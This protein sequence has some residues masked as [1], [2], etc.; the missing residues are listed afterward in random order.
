MGGQKYSKEEE[1]Q[2]VEEYRQGISVN[3]LCQKYG[4]KGKKSILD[5]VKKYYPDTY[6]DIMEEAKNNRSSWS[7]DITKIKNKFDAYLIGLL[8]T[9]GYITSDNAGF[10]ID[11]IDEDCI[12]FIAKQLKA[13]YKKYEYQENEKIFDKYERKPRFRIVL[14]RKGIVQQL[15]RFGIIKNKTYN[16]QPPQ[17]LEEEYQYV[18]YLIRGIIDGDGCVF[19]NSNNKKPNLYILTASKDFAD[20]LKHILTTRLFLQGVSI[21]IVKSND[22][23]KVDLYKVEVFREND[24]K[25]IQCLVYDE[26][27]GMERKFKKI[28]AQRL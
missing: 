23:K 13:S 4:Y 6:E 12:S 3:T 16:L 11:L 2:I 18:P 10:G 21:N 20:W 19:E 14:R 27:Y 24:I 26:P 17:L 25:K 15:E 9:D 8:L 22:D 1:L 7:W 28:D 5:K